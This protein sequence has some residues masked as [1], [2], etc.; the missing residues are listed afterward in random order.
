MYRP[1]MKDTSQELDIKFKLASHTL[2]NGGYVEIDFGNWTIDPAE[3]E[4]RTIW[5][6][7]VGSNIYWVPSEVT[8]PSGNVYR[9]HVYENYSMT[10][11]Q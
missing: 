9:V 4:G 6:Y 11:N 2:T 3:D 5:K 8:N 7:K 10:A 1:L